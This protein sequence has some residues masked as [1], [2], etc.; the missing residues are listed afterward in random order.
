M[1]TT[2]EINKIV[3]LSDS[4]GRLV[5]GELDKYM[6][7]CVRIINPHVIQQYQKEDGVAIGYLPYA[8]IE[9]V[10]EENVT[11]DF[12]LNNINIVHNDPTEIAANAYLQV[13]ERG[14][15]MVRKMKEE[16]E[17]QKGV[18]D[19]NIIKLVD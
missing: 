13:V 2:K 19:N 15:Q 7:D 5:I 18:V 8:Y 11:W 10:A 16:T 14:R 12:A 3:I 1:E 4:T 6:D 9:L 17:N